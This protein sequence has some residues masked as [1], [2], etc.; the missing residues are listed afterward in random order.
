MSDAST[1]LPHV[2]QASPFKGLLRHGFAA[3]GLFFATALFYLLALAVSYL[4]FPPPTRTA[5]LEVLAAIATSAVPI[6]LL[7]IVLREFFF[8]VRTERPPS[9]S[10]RLVQRVGAVL[11]DPHRM[12]SG[13]PMLLAFALFMFVFTAFKG[14]ITAMAPFAWDQAFDELDR[15]L[16]LGMRPW[17]L[18]HPVLSSGFAVFLLNLNYNGWFMVMNLFLIHFAFYAPPGE[19]RTRF[20]LTFIALWMVGGTLL[21]TLFSSAG[22]CY[23]AELG[24]GSEA[25]GPLM[26]RLRFINE[27]WSIWAVAT[28][29]MLWSLK[30]QGSA[31]GGVSAMPS[32]HNATAL[33]FIF[34][35]WE[36]G[37]A[38]RALVIAH[39]V[40]IFLG[41][42][43]L[44][45]HYAVDAYLAFA[46]TITFWL[47]LKPVA[48]WWHRRPAVSA[49]DAL[50]TSRS[51]A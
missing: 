3:H 13:L 32:M 21:A 2:A 14:Q 48:R 22:P 17:E 51:T 1:S 25:Y 23:F 27:Q 20:F 35:V 5:S 26:Q 33:L 31:L 28:Q 38:L 37:G 36:K 45:W 10:K 18:L 19:E 46:L 42:V 29:E 50:I 11:K 15:A 8:M 9:P 39:G 49:F 43:V 41:S 47:A 6:A 4:L 44:G 24:L 12:A 16:H 30:A 7:A 40:L 34:A